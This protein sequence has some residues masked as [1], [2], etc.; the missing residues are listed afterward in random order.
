MFSE[1]CPFEEKERYSI[2]NISAMFL[3]H[4]TGICNMLKRYRNVAA[5]FRTLQIIPAILQQ[6]FSVPAIFYVIWVICTGHV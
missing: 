3:Q 5:S 4:C 2:K 6:H 1:S